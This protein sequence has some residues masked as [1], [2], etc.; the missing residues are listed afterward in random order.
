MP[1]KSAFSSL[2]SSP[3]PS[4]RLFASA[5]SFSF[6][7]LTVLFLSACGSK[8]NAVSPKSLFPASTP[9]WTHSDDIR[10][11]APAQ[12]SDYIDGDAEKYLRA[13]VQSTSTSDFKFQNKFDAVVDIYTFSDPSGA[14]AIFDSEPPAPGAATPQL[15]D[16]ARLYEQSL[17][18]RQGRHLVRIVA[19]QSNPQL[20][21]GILDLGKSIA[22]RLNP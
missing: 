21:Q 10:T 14:K 20:Q 5:L 9:S 22:P 2:P 4:A 18:F 1:A 13:N 6:F 15:G 7:L 8:S 12:L 11:F 16:A 17:I 3:Y 19:Y